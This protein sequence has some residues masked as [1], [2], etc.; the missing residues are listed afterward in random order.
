MTPELNVVF[1]IRL[2]TIPRYD[3]FTLLLFALASGAL[4]MFCEVANIH[5]HTALWTWLLF[6]VG[7]AHP[8]ALPFAF[9]LGGITVTFTYFTTGFLTVLPTFSPLRNARNGTIAG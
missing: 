1:A 9:F 8:L 6:G 4:E 7:F 3:G 5:E 2:I